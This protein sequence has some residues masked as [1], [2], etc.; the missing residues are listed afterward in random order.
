MS[1]RRPPPK[2][3]ECSGDLGLNMKSSGSR[4]T[5]V[6]PSRNGCL[7]WYTTRP[8]LSTKSRLGAIGGQVTLR[9][10]RSSRLRCQVSQTGPA[11]RE[12]P[13]LQAR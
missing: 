10:N 8:R 9:H 5:S 6:D 12:K 2:Q 4:T 7:Y 13:A 11:C 3:A 1:G